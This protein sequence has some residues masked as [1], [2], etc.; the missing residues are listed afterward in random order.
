M[1]TNAAGGDE[2]RPREMGEGE[3]GKQV[4]TEGSQELGGRRVEAH[5]VIDPGIVDEDVEGAERLN[6]GGHGAAARF[7]V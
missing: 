4:A 2:V 1:T 3:G 5:A 6:G 7:V